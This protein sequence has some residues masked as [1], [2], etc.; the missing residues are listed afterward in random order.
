MFI[1]AG[2]LSAQ[3]TLWDP[4]HIT[5]SVITLR[6]HLQEFRVVLERAVGT[7][8]HEANGSRKEALAHFAVSRARTTEQ[9]RRLELFLFCFLMRKSPLRDVICLVPDNGSRE[10]REVLVVSIVVNVKN[11]LCWI[12]K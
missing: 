1:A 2:L 12:V 3:G 7:A 5:L 4:T 11:Y 8:I 10:I 6:I 9:H